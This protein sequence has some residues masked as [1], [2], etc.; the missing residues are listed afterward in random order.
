[1]SKIELDHLATLDCNCKLCKPVN[2]NWQEE[3]FYG[4]QCFECTNGKTAFII[5]DEHK[6]TLTREQWQTYQKLA[7]KHYP[8]LVSK[9]LS[10]KRRSCQ[11]WYEF[12]VRKN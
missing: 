7:A 11:H 12:L 9:G 5:L 6:G 10:E 4:Y 8:D 2:K 1:M 3:G